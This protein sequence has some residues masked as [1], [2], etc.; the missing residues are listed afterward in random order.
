L[1]HPASLST[2]IPAAENML[3]IPLQSL[4]P[5]IALHWFI[6]EAGLTWVYFFV[7]E[8]HQ[9]TSSQLV[10]STNKFSLKMLA[11]ATC[12]A[13]DCSHEDWPL[14]YTPLL[15]KQHLADRKSPFLLPLPEHHEPVKTCSSA[16]W[17]LGSRRAL[18]SQ[19]GTDEMVPGATGAVHSQ[20]PPAGTEVAFENTSPVQVIPSHTLR[21][22]GW[23]LNWKWSQLLSCRPPKLTLSATLSQ[24]SHISFH[25]VHFQTQTPGLWHHR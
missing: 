3:D 16:R 24:F 22:S 8:I 17:S 13:L 11:S 14:S 7:T 5:G 20:H 19:A 6:S 12:C 21:S 4:G 10:L 1:L 23:P 2:P 18:L 25:Q 9:G 15:S